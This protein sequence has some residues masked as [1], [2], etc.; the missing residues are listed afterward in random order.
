MLK[1]LFFFLT[2]FFCLWLFYIKELVPVV[3]TSWLKERQDFLVYLQGT[4]ARTLDP[5]R[6][7]DL[8]SARVLANIYEGLVR[9][10]A[11]TMEVEPCLATRWE[12]SKDGLQWTFYLRPNVTFHDGTPFNA[13]A[14]KFNVERLLSAQNRY[15][16]AAFTCGMVQSVEVIDPLTV[17]FTLKYPYAPFLYNLAMPVAAPMVSPKAVQQYQDQFWQHPAGTGPFIFEKWEQNKEIILVANSRY[18]GVKPAVPGVIF[19][20]VPDPGM[21]MQLLL[22]GKAHIGEG[23]PAPEITA[24]KNRGFRVIQTPGLDISYLGFYTNK[25]LFRDV[26]LRRA[27][28]QAC[29]PQALAEQLF[30]GETITARGPLPPGIP[31]YEQTLEPLP[32]GPEEARRQLI[33]AG[34]SEGLKITLLAYA[35][36]RPYNPAGG[37]R[38]A[39]ALAE[40]LQRAG[41]ICSIKVFPWEEFKKA[42]LR[43]EGD[44]FIY[45][46]TSDNGDPDNFLYT[47]FSSGQ[48]AC[49]FNTT[50][51]RNP[52][53]D[54]LLITAQ[55]TLDG[56]LRTRIYQ[57]VLQRIQDDTPMVFLHHSL[58]TLVTAG[59]IQGVIMRPQGIPFL[60]SVQISK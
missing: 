58:H 51:Y 44:A 38:L 22:S 29:D 57:N 54:T 15:T 26:A 56:S 11:G 52:Q 8:A 12:V 19:R 32:P 5:A 3:P 39:R 6:A 42:L 31:G 24:L 40:Q 43:Q 60:G 14:V 59:D 9:L 36:P 13:E 20:T 37:E 16:Y 25:G 18:W 17:R 46:W 1:R 23:I 41:F 28:R 55:Q 7:D 49:G 33:A 53:V 45:G 48:I 21:R 47:L 35:N 10:R 4:D 30:P 2:L 50:R 27:A 34:Y